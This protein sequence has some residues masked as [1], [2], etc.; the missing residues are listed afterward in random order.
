M[1]LGNARRYHLPTV[2]STNLH[3]ARLSN[4]G[5]ELPFWVIADE[6]TAGRGRN[7]RRWVSEPG[8]LYASIAFAPGCEP[9][10][11][12]QLGIVAAVAVF[13]TVERWVPA[14]RTNL[15]WP[16]DCL[17]DGAKVS[18]ILIES[19]NGASGSIVIGCGINVVSKP[20]S[21][22]YPTTSLRDYHKDV[23]TM[24]VFESLHDQL[25]AWLSVWQRGE[26]FSRIR[27]EWMSR[28]KCRGQSLSVINGKARIEGICHGLNEH[29]A[30]MLERNDGTIVPVYAGD[31]RIAA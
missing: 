7:D 12:P 1:P 6:Q 26:M 4:S 21:P 23:P 17:V 9:F 15:K 14:G 18:G 8:N 28:A 5:Q 16:N 25:S 27:E 31:V 2:D 30:L 10:H 3:A 19:L 13:D 20:S 22:D 29:G 24:A 11:L